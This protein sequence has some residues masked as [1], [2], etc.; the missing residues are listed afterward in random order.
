MPAGRKG[1]T[2]GSPMQIN[3]NGKQETENAYSQIPE[4]TR[5]SIGLIIAGSQGPDRSQHLVQT[6]ENVQ[7]L[8]PNALPDVFKHPGAV[9]PFIDLAEIFSEVFISSVEE[10]VAKF[11]PGIKDE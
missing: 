8:F 7:H 6:A 2:Y 9:L 11:M 3:E 4:G 1:Y 5:E 10:Y